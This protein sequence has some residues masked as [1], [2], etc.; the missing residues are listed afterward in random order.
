MG[1]CS[2]Q[3]GK[4]GNATPTLRHHQ[5]ARSQLPVSPDPTRPPSR[6]KET[7]RL[8]AVVTCVG[9]VG[10][11]ECPDHAG[12]YELVP[13]LSCHASREVRPSQSRAR[14]RED[15]PS[16]PDRPPLARRLEGD[17]DLGW[18]S[19]QSKLAPSGRVSTGVYRPFMPRAPIQAWCSVSR[20]HWPDVHG[21]PVKPAGRSVPTSSDSRPIERVSRLSSWQVCAYSSA[22]WSRISLSASPARL[23]TQICRNRAF[24]GAT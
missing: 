17:A 10:N 9:A 15:E 12:A 16:Q 22:R 3:P 11:A 6:P 24:E 18:R 20:R 7:R 19:L 8:Q 4:I 14:S 23:W 5:I 21:C 13:K 2:H 1:R